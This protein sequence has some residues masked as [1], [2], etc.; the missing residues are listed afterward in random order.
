MRL[1]PMRGIRRIAA[2]RVSPCVRG[3]ARALVQDL[4]HGGRQPYVHRR[5]HERIRHAVAML[6]HRD[7]IVDVHFRRA[8]LGILVTRRRQWTQCGT[9]RGL[10][11]GASRARQFLERPLVQRVQAL[12]Q[13]GIQFRERR[14]AVMPQRREQLA[15]DDLYRRF[16][17]GFVTRRRDPR[18]QN[19]R[20]IVRREV[21]IRRIDLG[22]VVRRGRHAGSQVIRDDQRRHAAEVLEHPHVRRDPVGQLLRPVASAYVKLLAP[23]TPTKICAART[24]PVTGSVMSTVT[25]A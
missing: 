14:E 25:P 3:D 19:R 18:R 12:T 15:L 11:E 16:H 4:T 13:R 6:L 23:K 9:I 22:R 5:A 20:A 8:P 17:F 10:E 7:V 21:G 2:R 1:R 24:S